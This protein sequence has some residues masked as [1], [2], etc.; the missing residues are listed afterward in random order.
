MKTQAFTIIILIFVIGISKLNGQD[1]DW[2]QKNLD[3]VT[4]RNGDT[5][6]EAKTEIEWKE[7]GILGDPVWCYANNDPS[8]NDKLGKLYNYYAV[9]DSRGLAPKG[10]R[11]PV[12][13]D[14][15]IYIALNTKLKSTDEVFINRNDDGTFGS[16]PNQWTIVSE[17]KTR[18]YSIN[19]LYSV[20]VSSS[21]GNGYP[22]R[23]IK[24]EE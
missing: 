24:G 11:I 17:T 22:V 18:A 5:I 21:K 13:K 3:I 6:P 12:K 20:G 4:F 19:V 10:Y 16:L 8:T 7:A 1:T 2:S 14:F 23:C 9:S 15:T